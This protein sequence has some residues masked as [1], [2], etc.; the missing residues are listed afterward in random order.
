MKKQ[1][2]LSLLAVFTLSI[3]FYSCT[4]KSEQFTG[5][6][7]KNYFPLEIGKHIIYDVDSTIWDDFFC[8]KTPH[9]YQIR[10][11]IADTFRDNQFRL[12]YRIDTHIRPSDTAEWKTHRVLYVTPTETTLEMVEENL[13]FTKMIF[14]IQNGLS[15]NGNAAIS[16]LDADFQLYQNWNYYYEKFS[17]PFNNGFVYFDNTVTVNAVDEAVNNPET[18]PGNYASR[19][20]SKEIFA[21]GVGMIYREFYH[22]TYTPSN[23]GGTGCRKGVGVVMRAIDH[24]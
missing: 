20:F 13:R 14:P 5:D 18:Q 15:W 4:K 17:E 22:W 21:Q 12:S 6:Y 7:S 1:L 23:S 9:S 8:V 11:D 19:T 10:W 24:N 2:L 3:G 16:K